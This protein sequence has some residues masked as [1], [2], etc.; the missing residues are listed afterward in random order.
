MKIVP[1]VKLDL[2][3]NSYALDFYKHGIKQAICRDNGLKSGDDFR[4]LKDFMLTLK[5]IHLSL[6]EM[7]GSESKLLK[8]I[9]LISKN[10]LATYTK[11]YGNVEGL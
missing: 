2:E 11:A 4:L 10:F 7:L 1:T 6:S 3:Y 9:E 5:S 8:A